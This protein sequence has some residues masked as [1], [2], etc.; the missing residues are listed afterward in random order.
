MISQTALMAIE[1]KDGRYRFKVERAASVMRSYEDRLLR[2]R[3][4]RNS[5][6]CPEPESP[7]RARTSRTLSSTYPL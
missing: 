1:G 3:P 7:A 5:F 6:I 4:C 2:D